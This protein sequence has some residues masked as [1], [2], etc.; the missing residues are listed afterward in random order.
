VCRPLNENHAQPGKVAS[1]AGRAVAAASAAQVR[2][3]G[4]VVWGE[5]AEQ[6]PGVVWGERAEQTPGVVWGER[7]EQTPGVVW[8]ERAEQTP[9]VVWGERAEQMRRISPASAEPARWAVGRVRI[10][11]IGGA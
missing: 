3:S 1:G 7:A 5:R 4:W 9:G 8:G 11:E 2:G 6:T 10:R